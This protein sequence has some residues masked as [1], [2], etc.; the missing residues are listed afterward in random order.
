MW[1]LLIALICI[2]IY[3]LNGRLLYQCADQIANK[4]YIS[5]VLKKITMSSSKRDSFCVSLMFL[6]LIFQICFQ[7]IRAALIQGWISTV[8]KIRVDMS[9]TSELLFNSAVQYFVRSSGFVVYTIITCTL[10]EYIICTGYRKGVRE[11]K[12][13]IVKLLWIIDE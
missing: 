2:L 8:D 13:L 9:R 4:S 11:F 10:W 7:F 12:N 3:K 5:V 1:E 6:L